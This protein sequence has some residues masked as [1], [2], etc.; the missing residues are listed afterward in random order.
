MSTPSIVHE[1]A[2]AIDGIDAGVS[3]RTLRGRVRPALGDINAYVFGLLRWREF[4][5]EPA[6]GFERAAV[7]LEPTACGRWC[8][9]R[10]TDR[11]PTAAENTP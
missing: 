3:V 5:P 1:P 2:P 9:Y 7:H 4:A 11:R 6:A 8:E 10:I